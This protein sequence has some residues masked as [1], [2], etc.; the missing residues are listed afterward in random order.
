MDFS[1]QSQVEYECRQPREGWML[2][3]ESSSLTSPCPALITV[4]GTSGKAP[5]LC[6]QGPQQP[7]LS[8][9]AARNGR[10]RSVSHRDVTEHSW[11]EQVQG[12]PFLSSADSPGLQFLPALGASSISCP[13]PAWT[14]PVSHI[15]SDQKCSWISEQ[16]CC[17]RPSRALTL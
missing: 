17:L 12:C 7:Q 4:V 1:Q 6:S 14:W 15:P 16:S 10:G 11:H 2:L 13:C 3:R 8:I 5:Q 9:F